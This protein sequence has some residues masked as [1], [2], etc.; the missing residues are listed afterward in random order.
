MQTGLWVI[1]HECGHGAFSDYSAVN[2]AVG[3]V[4][5]SFLLVPYF[6]WKYTHAKHHAKTGNMEGDEV[7]VPQTRDQVSD[8]PVMHSPVIRAI[9]IVVMLTLG[10]P[11]Y[12]LTN[13]TG[14]RYE[15]YTSHFTPFTDLF[16]TRKQ[17]MGVVAS[18]AGIVAMIGA[19]AYVSHL[20]GFAWV[21]K[22]YGIPYL[23]VNMWLVLITELQHTD[24]WLPHFRGEQWNWLRGALATVDRDYGFLNAVF[25]HIGDTHVC[26]HIFS[27]MPHY[28]AEEATEAI[29]PILGKY[30]KMDRTPIAVALWNSFR[31]CQYVPNGQGTLWFQSFSNGDHVKVAKAN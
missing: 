4:V 30:Y 21:M 2:D 20:K 22:M 28:H 10:W 11:L 6:S 24:K 15:T 9:Q 18:D 17:K 25:H 31:D 3:F 26:H 12:L 23:F 19:I 29:K 8:N 16:S 5:H 27:Y 1:A 14:Q 7:F 13:V